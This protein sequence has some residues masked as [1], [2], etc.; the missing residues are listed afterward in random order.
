MAME[1]DGVGKTFAGMIAGI[2]GV[3]IISVV[4]SNGSNTVN[5]IRAFFG[6]FSSILAIAVSPTTGNSSGATS[7]IS[8]LVSGATNNGGYTSA[9]VAGGGG[10]SFGGSNG[11]LGGSIGLSGAFI[12]SALNGLFSGGSVN[13]TSSNALDTQDTT[14]FPSGYIEPPIPPGE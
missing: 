2:I 10:L 7:A 5:V 4:L 6:G 3:A 9:S 11:T 8:Q 1:S 13:S 14:Q 12:G